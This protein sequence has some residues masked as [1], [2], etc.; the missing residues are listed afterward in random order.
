MQ[1][2]HQ[3]YFLISFILMILCGSAWAVTKNGFVLDEASIPVNQ[4]KQG[5]PPRD[6]IPALN[7][8]AFIEADKADYLDAKDR[9]LGVLVNGQARAYPISILDW[10]EVVNDKVDDQ[11]FSVTYCP[12]CGTGIVFAT[13]FDF[14]GKQSPILFS[15]SGLLY[16]SDVLLYDRQ[17]ES[18][19]SQM[20]GAAVVGPFKGT[21]LPQLPVFHTRWNA[22]QKRHP[23]TL[24]MSEETGVK[25]D[26]SNSPYSGYEKTRQLYFSVSRKAP[27]DYHPKEQ[28][29]GVE[30]DGVYKAY[31]FTELAQSKESRFVDELNGKALSIIWDSEA[32]S[33]HVLDDS[34]KPYVSLTAYWF[35]WYTFH[36]ETHIYNAR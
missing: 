19:W 31:P 7:F 12:L 29:L 10:H 22:W 11:H 18:L 17:T 35:A 14:N 5:G 4:I 33:A 3:I 28:V 32:N 34:S 30:V 6:G 21:E 20:L 13:N 8:P 36:P 27:K 1:T 15:V 9:I 16:E 26:Y 2:R 25:R 23:K 24:V